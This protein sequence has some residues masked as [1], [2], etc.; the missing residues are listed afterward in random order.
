MANLIKIPSSKPVNGGNL[1]SLSKQLNLQQDDA[2]WVFGLTKEKWRKLTEQSPEDPLDSVTL[3]LMVRALNKRPDLIPKKTIQTNNDFY[4]EIIKS[5]EINKRRLSIMFGCH[6]TTTRKDHKKGSDG[7]TIQ[8]RLALVFDAFVTVK[9]N[10]SWMKTSSLGVSSAS[11]DSIK[12]RE[13]LKAIDEWEQWIHVEASSRGIEDIY[14]KKSWTCTQASLIEK[15]PSGVHLL[16]LQKTL[17]LSTKDASWLF[18]MSEAR[19]SEMTQKKRHEP[20]KSPAL[21]L[22]VRVLSAY[23][24]ATPMSGRPDVAHLYKSVG[25]NQKLMDKRRLGIMFGC[26]GSSGHRL[27]SGSSHASRTLSQ[28]MKVFQSWYGIGRNTMPSTG[29]KGEKALMKWDDI[30]TMEAKA[31]GVVDVFN[32]GKWVKKKNPKEIFHQDEQSRR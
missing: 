22:M 18:G 3:S 24:E 31:R 9:S 28:L 19:W 32:T 16:A 10:P 27:L 1:F 4:Q 7:A 29:E 13:M 5:E 6:A 17:S 15:R 2:C 20:I 8:K 21:S 23:P 11:L 26:E 12:K 30:V 14:A 25:I